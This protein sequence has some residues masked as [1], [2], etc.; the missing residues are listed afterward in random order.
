MLYRIN[1]ICSARSLGS[2]H[3]VDF[4]R[5]RQIKLIWYYVNRVSEFAVPYVQIHA[6]RQ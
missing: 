6:M 4:I 1:L 5:K 3:N 2:P